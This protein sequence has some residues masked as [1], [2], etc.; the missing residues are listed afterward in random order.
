MR[1]VLC[2]L[3]SFCVIHSSFAQIE[4]SQ[5]SPKPFNKGKIVLN[6]GYEKQPGSGLRGEAPKTCFS[7]G[8]GFTDWCVAGL[9]ANYGS[10]FMGYH[11][12]S[13]S[14]KDENGAPISLYWL[15]FNS[16]YLEYGTHAEFHPVNLM[17]PQF[18]FVDVYAIV[19]VGMHHFICDII[20]E[21]GYD[22]VH[23]TESGSLKNSA[24]PYLVG[25]WGVA[26]NPSRYFGFFY[27]RTHNTLTDFYEVS[28]PSLKHHLYHR[29]GF[30]IR[31]G[32]PKK[33]QKQ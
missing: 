2:I 28:T 11:A 14:G 22:E 3:I 10:D 13:I 30:N 16:N 8:Y 19:R 27:E 4:S 12:Y 15:E 24:T 32:G 18:Y 29:F 23:E 1:K 9:Y 17:L 5:A 25:G 31:F 20:S 21:T 6:F 26:I 33:W 7:A